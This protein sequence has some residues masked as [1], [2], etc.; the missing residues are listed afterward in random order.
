MHYLVTAVSVQP[1]RLKFFICRA[2][3]S[4]FLQIFVMSRE[5]NIIISVFS[6][7]QTEDE[8][9]SRPETNAHVF[10]C[11]RVFTSVRKT[12]T[13]IRQSRP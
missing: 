3:I 6:S 11:D 5:K 13:G 9:K 12:D 4:V 7:R 2:K 1:H 10:F 8:T